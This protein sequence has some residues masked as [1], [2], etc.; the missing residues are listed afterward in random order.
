VTEPEQALERARTAAAS[1]RAAG[2]Y[3]EQDTSVELTRGEALT[4]GKLFEWALI[5]PDLRNVRSTRR[6]GA[7]I[8]AL[9]RALL[10]LLGQYHAELI[11]EQ[12]RFNVNLVLYVRGLEDRVAEL[13]RELEH[14]E[15][16]PPGARPEPLRE[17]PER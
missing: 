15:R 16:D 9:K 6:L 1:M 11:A 17:D 2:G 13:E 5:E 8:T 10:R 12:A 3:G 14:A 7:P 4:S